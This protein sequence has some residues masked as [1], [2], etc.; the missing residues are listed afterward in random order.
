MLSTC[1]WRRFG[2]NLRLDLAKLTV[3]TR[4]H[5]FWCWAIVIRCI[6][7]VIRTLRT[8]TTII[9]ARRSKGHS[10][11]YRNSFFAP[12]ISVVLTCYRL[13]IKILTMLYPFVVTYN[14]ALPRISNILRKHF[15][16]LHSPNSCKDD[17]K[18]LSF[19]AYKRSPNLRDLLVKP[20]I[21]VDKIVPLVHTLP[22]GLRSY[23]FHATGET[24]SITSH[25]TCNTKNVICMVQCNRCN[26]QYIGETKQRLKDRFNEHRRAVDK[27]NIK[28]KPTTVSKHFLSHSNH[29][30]T[31]M[32]LIALERINS[33]SDSVRKARESHLIDK[34]MTL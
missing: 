12:P 14:P 34:A 17:F 16:T 24:R 11:S 30:H 32:Q 8:G 19:F 27:T 26:L 33:S 31:D 7:T 28:S 22:N 29:S 15:N 23:T 10:L 5:I 9:G 6:F 21:P 2:L 18:Q 3:Y 4:V 13:N 1:D 25:I 20:Q